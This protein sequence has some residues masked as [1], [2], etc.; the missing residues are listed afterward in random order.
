LPPATP[1]KRSCVVPDG[2]DICA[3]QRF[4]GARQSALQDFVFRWMCE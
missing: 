1:T 3:K 2:M 4:E